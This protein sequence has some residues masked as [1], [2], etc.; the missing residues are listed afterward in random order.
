MAMT[1]AATVA[2]QIVSDLGI[3]VAGQTLATTEWTHVIARLQAM[4]SSGTVS[5]TMAA[6]I[7]TGVQTGSGTATTTGTS[8]GSLT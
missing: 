1:P 8:T 5:V 2:A 6:G 3:P 7:T 4:I